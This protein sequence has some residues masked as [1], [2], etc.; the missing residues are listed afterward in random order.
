LFIGGVEIADS[1]ETL[2]LSLFDHHID[3]GAAGLPVVEREL[4][5]P[6]RR[7]LYVELLAAPDAAVV[8]ARRGAVAIGY[9][10]VRV[11]H[12][13]DDTWPTGELIGEVES[14]AVVASERGHGVGT[15]LLDAGEEHLSAMGAHDVLIGVLAGNDSALE[16]Y[17]RRRMT[18][19]LVTMLRLG[20]R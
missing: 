20:P 16:F 17:R 3:I 13:A 10:L 1:L 5:W 11:H 6:R 9:C 12:G 14:L 2:W 4:S 18:P 19:A 7:R 15:L 8:V